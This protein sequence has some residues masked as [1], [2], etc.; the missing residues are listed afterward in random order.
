MGMCF[1]VPLEIQ[2]VWMMCHEREERKETSSN[3]RDHNAKTKFV[4]GDGNIYWDFTVGQKYAAFQEDQEDHQDL[5][6]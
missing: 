3:W 4:W 2:N 6:W 5:L 1:A